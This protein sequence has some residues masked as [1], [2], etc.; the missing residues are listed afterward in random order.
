MTRPP[1]LFTSH[2]RPSYDGVGPNIRAAAHVD[3]LSAFFDVHV[4]HVEFY[5]MGVDNSRFVDER[6]ASFTHLPARNGEVAIEGLVA[7][8]WPDVPFAAMH[9]YRLAS[10]RITLGVLAQLKGVRPHLHLD[11]DD[12]DCLREERTIALMTATGDVAGAAIQQSELGRLR[13]LERLLAPRFDTLSLS[14]DPGTAQGRFPQ[15]TLLHLPNVVRMPDAA[16]LAVP[17]PEKASYDV[18]FSGSLNYFPN[19]EGIEYFC[20]EV[21][22]RLRARVDKPVRIRIVGANP[23]LRVRALAALDGVTLDANVPDI[24]PYYRNVDLC[25]VPLRAASGTRLKILDAFSRR[26]AVVATRIG[27]EDLSVTDGLHLLLADDTEALA[28][29]CARVLQDAALRQH[30]VE[31]AFAWV[32]SN[33][34]VNSLKPIMASIYAP[35]LLRT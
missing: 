30:L 31:N 33:H 21:L 17:A 29:A 27:A 18:L 28:T 4:L 35:V 8:R 26:C 13:T 10:A 7:R 22:P 14:G 12:D 3:A 9:T 6:A 5:T 2:F 25:V 32:D 20:R 23:D 24:A 15:R 16:S 11:L 1:L 19:A 34:T